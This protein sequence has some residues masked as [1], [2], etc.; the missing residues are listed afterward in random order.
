MPL[1]K[2]LCAAA[3]LDLGVCSP[4]LYPTPEAPN[5]FKRFIE[6]LINEWDFDN[7]CSA[8]NGNCVGGAKQKLRQT[9][10]SAEPVLQ[11]I[12]SK[13]SQRC[14]MRACSRSLS[15][16]FSR[17]PSIL[18]PRPCIAAAAQP[19]SRTSSTVE[20]RSV[21]ARDCDVDVPALSHCEV[22]ILE[23]SLFRPSRARAHFRKAKKDCGAWSSDPND[24]PDCG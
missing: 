21:R 9:L 15:I 13:N 5:E 12:S 6:L 22:C 10:R 24:P 14:S 17:C 4:G 7:I 20:R 11:K 18:S 16:Q 1:N 2:Q 8:H 3:G 19:Q 23:R